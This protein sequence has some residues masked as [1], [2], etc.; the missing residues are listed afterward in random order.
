VVFRAFDWAFGSSDGSQSSGIRTGRRR[1]ALRSGS[2]NRGNNRA[3][4]RPDLDRAAL[5][6]LDRGSGGDGLLCL[7][8]DQSDYSL[9]PG[10]LHHDHVTIKGDAPGVDFG[11]LRNVVWE[12]LSRL[13][14]H[15][16]RAGFF[17]ARSACFVG[18]SPHLCHRAL[19]NSGPPLLPQGCAL[20]FPLQVGTGPSGPL[21]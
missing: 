8:C 21:P 18:A 6:A 16:A 17:Y 15:P 20:G 19:S 1:R 14:G 7:E 2:T 4:G 13:A 12:W 3:F 9:I 11:A 10:T 5:G